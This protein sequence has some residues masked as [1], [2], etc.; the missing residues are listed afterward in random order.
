ML[1]PIPMR[2]LRMT[3]LT[4]AFMVAGC[5]PENYSAPLSSS[6]CASAWNAGTI[7]W[8][9][10]ESAEPT[11]TVDL[12]G[13]RVWVSDGA[14]DSHCRLAVDLGSDQVQIFGSPNVTRDPKDTKKG[15]TWTIDTRLGIAPD[16]EFGMQSGGDF[17]ASQPGGWNACGDAG[18]RVILGSDCGAVTPTPPTSIIEHDLALVHRE[19]RNLPTG[20]GW[21][22]GE[23]YR[24]V[25]PKGMVPLP[26]GWRG[27]EVSYTVHVGSDRWLIN[28]VTVKRRAVSSPCDGMEGSFLCRNG[29]PV[30]SVV[31]MFHP[32]PQVTVTVLAAYQPKPDFYWPKDVGRPLP[33]AIQQDMVAHLTAM[34]RGR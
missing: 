15:F 17:A 20:T 28:V 21:W 1:G 6:D 5:H 11:S 29:S 23:Q 22:L 13:R 3:V 2:Y 34:T 27:T 4:L 7:E 9:R 24:G 30:G 31:G 10:G 12:A 16:A 33:T 14:S 8:M 26:V 19:V 32:K 18:N 25:T